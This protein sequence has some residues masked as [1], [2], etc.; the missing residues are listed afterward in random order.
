MLQAQLLV[1]AGDLGRLKARKESLENRLKSSRTELTQ[2]ETHLSMSSDLASGEV[3][4]ATKKCVLGHRA[5]VALLQTEF[6]Y[7]ALFRRATRLW[8]SPRSR[9]GLSS[10]RR[11]RC[12]QLLH[13]PPRETYMEP[14]ARR[15][16]RQIYFVP[17]PVNQLHSEY[18]NALLECK[19]A[20]SQRDWSATSPLRS[21]AT[22]FLVM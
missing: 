3:A 9:R 16:A 10:N 1:S 17:T 2:V 15:E 5:G 13:K 7:H 21:T 22:C 14:R 11:S 6:G 8:L 4:D 20:Q 18:N 19:I 12:T